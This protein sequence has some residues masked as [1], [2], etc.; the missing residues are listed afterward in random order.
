MDITLVL[1]LSGIKHHKIQAPLGQEK[2]VRG[3]HDFLTT[4]VPNI[5]HDLTRRVIYVIAGYRPSLD[6]IDALRLRLTRV[7]RLIKY[8]YFD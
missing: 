8:K 6:N 2:L 4:E 5:H 1:T 3:M 7:C